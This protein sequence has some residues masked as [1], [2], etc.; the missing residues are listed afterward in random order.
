MTP[1]TASRGVEATCSELRKVLEPMS[2]IH[3]ASV[4]LVQRL[5]FLAPP[6]TKSLSS[7]DLDNALVVRPL[8]DRTADT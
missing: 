4:L 7:F 1:S 3:Q 2:V 6:T 8:L 5:G